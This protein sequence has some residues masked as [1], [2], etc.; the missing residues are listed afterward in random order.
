MRWLLLKPHDKKQIH[1]LPALDLPFLASSLPTSLIDNVSLVVHPRAKKI[2]LRWNTMTG[3]ARLTVPPRTH[4]RALLS[5]LIKH[6]NWLQNK[7]LHHAKEHWLFANNAVIPVRGMDH[8]IVLT[9]KLRGM[10]TKENDE[11]GPYLLIPGTVPHAAR[12][13]KDYLKALA[14]EI[15]TQESLRF[16]SHID[17]QPLSITLK[18]T[19]TRWGSCSSRRSLS[20]NW[21]IIMAPPD[22]LTYL[23]AHEVAHFIHMNHK[24]P[25]WAQVKEFMPHYREAQLWLKTY[26]HRLHR[27]NFVCSSL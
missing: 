25:F 21:R 22:V 16:A 9:G 27:Y 6:Q 26:G 17:M 14:Q 19:R 4:E 7:M 15:L 5:F 1:T 3:K 23:C 18:D 2:I 12:K 8:R 11:N 10:V 24:P 13:L 20:Y